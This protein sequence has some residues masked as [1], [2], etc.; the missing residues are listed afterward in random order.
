MIVT[1]L[2]WPL[3]AFGLVQ[4]G[5]WRGKALHALWLGA[6]GI[7]F[8]VGGV[9]YAVQPSIRDEHALVAAEMAM[10]F[11]MAFTHMVRDL[12]INRVQTEHL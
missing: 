6:I 3:V 1:F 2:I 11:F 8:V 5:K 10:L 9:L 4:Y 12:L 7:G